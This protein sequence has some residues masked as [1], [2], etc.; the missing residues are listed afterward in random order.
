MMALKDERPFVVK[1]IRQV[2]F[3]VVVES[4][5]F[6]MYTIMSS[7]NSDTFISSF[8]FGCLLFLFL[9]WLLWLGLPM[10]CWIEV[11]KADILFVLLILVGMLL[12]FACG[13]WMLAVGLSYMACIMFRN[14]PSIS[15]LLCFYHKWVLYLTKCFLSIYWNDHVI[16]V[17]AVDVMYY[18]YWFVNIVP[19]LHPWDQFQL[20]M[21]YDLF[22]IL[23][24]V[25][26]QYFVED[27]SI[28]V[29]QRYWPV[30]SFLCCVFIW[31]WD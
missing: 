19:S 22:N 21:V 18:V 5:G 10:L 27:F 23:L 1:F 31:F 2:I 28:Y 13:L 8:P 30:V 26:C 9:V 3:F 20:I 11:V 6:S 4:I 24:D 29:H 12:V 17:F 25:D 14:A 16:F 15:T 7:A